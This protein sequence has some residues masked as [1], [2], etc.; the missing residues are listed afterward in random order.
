VLEIITPLTAGLAHTSFPRPAKH[1][2]PLRLALDPSGAGVTG[3]FENDGSAWGIGTAAATLHANALVW[4]QHGC[5]PL[6]PDEAAVDALE[7]YRTAGVD[8][9]SI[10]VGMDLTPSLDALKVLAAFRRGLQAHPDRYLIA[11]S[12]ADIHEAKRSG[13]L[14]V[15]FDLEGTE[16]VDGELALLGAFYD[17]GVRSVLI[18]Y[19]RRNRAGGGCHDDPETG[20]SAYGRTLVCEM[21][22]LGILVDA[23]H[24]SVRTTFDLFELSS[25]PVVFSHSVPAGIRAHARNVTDEQM[26]ACAATGGVI[27][28]NGLGIFLG[29][30]DA[31]TE[32]LVRAVDYA[33]SV[34]GAEHVGIGLDY[35]FDQK[36]INAQLEQHEDT[37]PTGGGYT[38]FGPIQF[39]SPSQLPEL[40][41]ALLQLGYHEGDVRA[42]LGGN[43]LRVASQVWM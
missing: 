17:L 38:E 2:S 4:D 12:V 40:T 30:N 6:H 13:R 41:A 39:A 24:C 20:L 5:L 21:N 37:F 23:T 36:E 26:R 43:F 1:D 42:I 19:N 10:N 11:S 32:A 9:V 8:V 35:V 31:S 18:A 7:L 29:E 33:V 16:P 28:I 34:V 15:T 27:G 22:E 25:Q 14:A 3:Q